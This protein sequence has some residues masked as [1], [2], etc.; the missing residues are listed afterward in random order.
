MGREHRVWLNQWGRSIEWLNQ[1]GRNIEWVLLRGNRARAFR[2]A[3][4]Q[5]DT[6]TD[7]QDT[8]THRG[9]HRHVP[10]CAHRFKL[11]R[12]QH[13]VRNRDTGELRTS[14]PTNSSP[15]PTCV[16]MRGLPYLP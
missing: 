3:H 4:T 2:C 13:A 12:T 14:K 9:T 10:A 11:L 8:Y 7:I 16:A 5:A 1:W 15:T 6:G